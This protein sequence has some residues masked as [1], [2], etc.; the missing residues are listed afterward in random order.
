MEENDKSGNDL[1]EGFDHVAERLQNTTQRLREID[2][3]IDNLPK[4]RGLSLEY[5]PPYFV[6]Q[7][8]GVQQRTIAALKEMQHQL[9]TDTLDKTEADTRNVDQKDGRVVRDQ[10]R[11]KLFPNPY[12]EFNR[13]DL[14]A[15]KHTI[16]E[17]EQSQ[18]YM[19]AQLVA[20][21]AERNKA[22]VKTEKA[23]PN[24]SEKDSPSVSPRFSL[25]LSYTKAT[26]KDD[27]TPS[28]TP[29]KGKDIDRE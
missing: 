13:E 18:D 27:S 3:Q 7:K 16:K 28:K 24:K 21:A 19:D 23:L 20:K 14:L 10:V 5:R 8:P 2:K 22:V 12:R 11:E 1:P 15:D 4:D 29:N 26:S 6:G 9:K 17:I 25:S